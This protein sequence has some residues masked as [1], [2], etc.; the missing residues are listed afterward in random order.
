MNFRSISLGDK[1][2]FHTCWTMFEAA[3]A[4]VRHE[5]ALGL[6]SMRASVETMALEEQ[7]CALLYLQ[8]EGTA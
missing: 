5:Q 8:V 1:A 4:A 3:M 2:S 6:L 7:A